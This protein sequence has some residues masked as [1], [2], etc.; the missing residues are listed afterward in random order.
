MIATAIRLQRVIPSQN[1]NG[2]RQDERSVKP[3][4]LAPFGA[5]YRGFQVFQAIPVPH[6]RRH[7][8]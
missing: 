8:D 6:V 7:S 5:S 1:P 3:L 2:L 4:Y